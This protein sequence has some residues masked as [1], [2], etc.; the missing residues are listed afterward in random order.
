[1]KILKNKLFIFCLLVCGFSV[2]VYSV[3]F[4][5]PNYML[6]IQI[7][8]IVLSLVFAK[9]DKARK[10]LILITIVITLL[11]GGFCYMKVSHN[12]QFLKRSQ[13]LGGIRSA[14]LETTDVKDLIKAVI[15]N[16]KK[17]VG[18]NVIVT[19]R[20]PQNSPKDTYKTI[21]ELEWWQ[22]EFGEKREWK[23]SV[24]MDMNKL[25]YDSNGVAPRAAPQGVL[26]FNAIVK[27]EPSVVAKFTD[28]P[29]SDFTLS[30]FFTNLLS[31]YIKRWGFQSPS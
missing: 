6:I 18:R 19:C 29:S 1:M 26:C 25:E 22:K 21:E 8:A 17:I 30:A 12:N 14:G 16:N 3:A 24:S 2:S 10:I 31:K 4:E 11:I 9:N 15:D 23:Y 7:S 27:T 13:Y 5:V 28:E 20:L